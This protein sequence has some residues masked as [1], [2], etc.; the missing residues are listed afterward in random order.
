MDERK[1]TQFAPAERAGEETLRRQEAA[2]GAGMG[3]EASAAMGG[4]AAPTMVLNAQRQIVYANPAARRLMEAGGGGTACGRRPG[5]ALECA[6]A[7]ETESG[8]GTT[9]H[10]RTCGAVLAI[11]SAQ[12]GEPDVR[13]CRITKS[14]R[15]AL[16]LRIWT[17][18][19]EFGGEKY[20]VLSALDVADEKRRRALERVFF[21]D[22]L[23]AAA[24]LRGLSEL[25]SGVPADEAPKFNEMIRELAEKLIEDIQ[26]QRD[27]ANAENHEYAAKPAEWR[28]GAALEEACNMYRGLAG[29]HG[30]RLEAS[31]SRA[32]A[33]FTSD[34]VLVRRVLGNLIKNAVEA[35]Q[36]GDAVTVDCA[37]A[38]GSATFSVH[39]PAAMPEEARLQM[40]QR[41]FSTKGGGRGLGTYSV[42]L[43]A[44]TYLGGKATFRS[45]EGEGTTFSVELPLE[46]GARI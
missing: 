18:P 14:D 46:W 10:C 3:K 37:V 26:A 13:E 28:T 44:E 20:T 43:F 25:V 19:I 38:G 6:H 1:P 23:N 32:D 22:I 27:L 7:S 36:P 42:K 21:H 30:V 31:P 16:D 40:F 24:G 34:K 9:E 29:T 4:V 12:G 17:M 15:E 11:L 33:G 45:A 35:S 8:C 5:E 41:S 2:V 39:N